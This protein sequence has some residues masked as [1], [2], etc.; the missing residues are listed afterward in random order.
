M[1]SVPPRVEIRHRPVPLMSF[2]WIAPDACPDAASVRARIEQRFG[3]PVDGQDVTVTVVRDGDVFIARVE[4]G[5]GERTLADASCALLADAVAIVVAGS[6]GEP[7]APVTVEPA[8]VPALP[9]LPQP[10]VDAVAAPPRRPTARPWRLGALA[11]TVAAVG[12]LPGLGGGGELAADVEYGAWVGEFG[13][14]QWAPSGRSVEDFGVDRIEVGL[15]AAVLRIGR[16]LGTLPARALAT[17][18][19]GEMTGSGWGSG[20]GPWATVGGRAEAWWQATRWLRVVASAELDGAADRV[21]FVVAPGM[22][23]YEA[24]AWSV[25][26]GVGVEILAR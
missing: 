14:Q 6:L 26:A 11:T 25:Q 24:P 9:A 13:V 22:P 4:V 16:R 17:A 12:V 8:P 1:P 23:A 19:L 15:R 10:G 21:D 5:G 20:R 18:S 2:A 7:P 3:G